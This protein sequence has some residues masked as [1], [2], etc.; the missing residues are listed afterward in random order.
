MTIKSISTIKS[1]G[2]YEFNGAV[3]NVTEVTSKGR[4]RG[5][6]TLSSGKEFSFSNSASGLKARIENDGL[7]PSYKR[8][9]TIPCGH[10][11]HSTCHGEHVTKHVSSNK[12]AKQHRKLMLAMNDIKDVLNDTSDDIVN[13]IQARWYEKAEAVRKAMDEIAAKKRAEAEAREY[14]EAEKLRRSMIET[15]AKSKNLT[16]EVAEANLSALGII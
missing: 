2:S 10:S 5:T 15:Y 3:V 8:S 9:A 7:N 12:L 16:L 11:D 13:L 4:L 1:A 6:C 14:A